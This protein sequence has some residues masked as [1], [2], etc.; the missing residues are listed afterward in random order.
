MVPQIQGTPTVGIGHFGGHRGTVVSQKRAISF[1]RHPI[2]I[3]FEFKKTLLPSQLYET[4]LFQP[5]RYICAPIF[6]QFSLPIQKFPYR[7]FAKGTVV[8]M[9]H[10]TKWKDLAVVA[11]A[12]LLT[13]NKG[14]QPDGEG[15]RIGLLSIWGTA[16]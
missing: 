3:F 10:A 2:F 14:Q 5:K 6:A 13:L 16:M 9:Q 11:T 7:P 8:A 4:S 15:A 12:V 1:C